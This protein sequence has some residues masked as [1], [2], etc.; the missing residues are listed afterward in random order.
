MH[1]VAPDTDQHPGGD[2]PASSSPEDA[3]AE[4]A[5]ERASGTEAHERLVMMSSATVKS[6]AALSIPTT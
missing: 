3:K 4:K 6:P 2:P 5:Q 1:V